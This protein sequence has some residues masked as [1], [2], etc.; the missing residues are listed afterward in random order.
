M[1]P[2]NQAND[3]ADT[4][5]NE[6][7]ANN[8]FHHSQFNDLKKLV[9][10]KQRQGLVISLCL[11]T[12]NEEKTIGKEVVV[13]KSELMTRYPL[14]DE[15]AVWTPAPKIAQE[16]QQLPLAQMYTL[17]PKFCLKPANA[18]AKAKTSGKPFTNSKAIS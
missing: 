10:E 18:G 13:F 6:W 12:L 15:I 2:N 1:N 16:K 4:R 5:I 11:P 9:E 3:P 8:T 7:L 14:V 17:H